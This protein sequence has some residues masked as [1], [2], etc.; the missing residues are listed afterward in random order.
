VTRRLRR[1]R[2]S[3]EIN[4]IKWEK[5]NEAREKKSEVERLRN[6]LAAKDLEVQS[7][8]D[9]Q[10]LASQIEVESGGS[11]TTN[12]TLSAKV[13][14]LE[15]EIRD[16]KAE[17]QRK[18]SDTEQDPNWTI[19]ERDPFDFDDDDDDDHMITNYDD[20]FRESMM[21]DEMIAT[22]TR[23]NTSFPSP[24][25]TMPN[26]PCKSVSSMNAGI[27]TSLPIPDPENE[28]LKSQL[29]SLQSEISKLTAAI[30]FNDDNQ[31]RLAQKLSE[32]IPTD[33]F[34]DHS[35]LDSALD[36]VL[37]Q[38]ALSQSHALEHTTAFSALSNEI[39]NLGF[40]CSGPE[41]TLEEIASQF[42]Q[43]RLDLEY[44]T[45]G[46]VVEGFEND[47]LL[48]MLVSRIKFLL[49]RVKE[50]DDSIDQYHE[51]E[52]L[53]RQQID[54][55]VTVMEEMRNELVLANSVRGD[56]REEI[57]EKEVGNERLKEALEGYRQEVNGLEKL[58]ERLEHDNSESTT[59]LTRELT[60]TQ[61][62]LQDEILQHD[63]L[64]AD[65]EGKEMII[66]E[67]DKRLTSALQAAA[68]VQTQL[69]SLT[70]SHA[71]VIAEKDATIEQMKSSAQDR[72]K[73]YG[74]ALALLDA[75]VSELCEEIERVNTS[76]ET[77]YTKIHNLQ[78]EKSELT[79]KLEGEESQRKLMGTRMM[80]M[81]MQMRAEDT[82]GDVSM[83]RP[84][85]EGS[86]LIE[87]G[88][89]TPLSLGVIKEKPRMMD[90]SL[91]RRRSQSGKKRRRYDSGLGF[92][93]EVDEGVMS[94]DL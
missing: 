82:N 74:D 71:S 48:E 22:P 19:A 8:R 46:E 69:S 68:E 39:T 53:L 43:A 34:H 37:T 44:L 9:K 88:N 13:Q 60:S 80:Q 56:L 85:R 10:D 4:T 7:M 17:L 12:T 32:F 75:R 29:Q 45:P 26:T 79:A 14:E 90:G 54:T 23:L 78:K 33:E 94:S 67:L 87:C 31:T 2:L 1:N 57:K 89:I 58:I 77:A 35:T 62:K 36:T 83:Q 72:E 28:I 93:E 92:L 15:Q 30:A 84:S 49:Q 11:I 52:L 55:R 20:D 61:E 5:R 65:Q 51:Q 27:Q 42:R 16:L 59:S 24:P 21:N 18:E 41:E 64:K 81:G 86:S 40:S 6:E 3:E 76:L 91:A 47:K 63:V 38:L 50:R 70:T 73:T 25:S 66:N